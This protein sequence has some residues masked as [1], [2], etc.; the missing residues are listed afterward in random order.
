MKKLAL[1]A[2]WL[3]LLIVAPFLLPVPALAQETYSGGGCPPGLPGDQYGEDQY[4]AGG[5]SYGPC[6]EPPDGTSP[7]PGESEFGWTA[8]AEQNARHAFERSKGDEGTKAAAAFEEAI[9]A[10]RSM[11][12]DEQTARVAAQEIVADLEAEGEQK[13]AQKPD[14]SDEEKTDPGGTPA[15]GAVS[16]A[17]FSP[18]AEAAQENGE[19]AFAG[20]IPLSSVDA[21][22][23]LGA[24]TFLTLTGLFVF[25]GLR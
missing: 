18:A 3:G 7:P 20:L 11:G 22:L 2:G 15:S 17:P 24:L 13:T 10:A 16:E 5:S 25:R 8:A 23:A 9:S 4:A 6:G 14:V 1:M 12:V 19:E 21:R